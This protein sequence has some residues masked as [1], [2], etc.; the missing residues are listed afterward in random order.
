MN[1]LVEYVARGSL[2]LLDID[3]SEGKVFN[4]RRSRFIDGARSCVALCVGDG[5]LRTL[6][7]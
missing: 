1:R 3:G 5:E 4:R 2:R 6:Q 7:A